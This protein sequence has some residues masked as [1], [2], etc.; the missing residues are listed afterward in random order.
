MATYDLF[1]NKNLLDNKRFHRNNSDDTIHKI[2]LKNG[3]LTSVLLIMSFLAFCGYTHRLEIHQLSVA[4]MVLLA[5]GVYFAIENI[6]PNGKAGSVDYFEGFKVGLYT[7]LVAVVS[8]ALFLMIYTYFN[9]SIL[10]EI[11]NGRYGI[12]INPLTVAGVTLFEEF[13]AA[14]II[15]FCLMQ[16]FKKN[17][18]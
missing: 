14:I 9:N 11:K 18:Y 2:C 8:H 16:Y 13:A 10:L 15:T 5:F 4:N 6:S 12:A 3:L 17:E 7:A 1:R